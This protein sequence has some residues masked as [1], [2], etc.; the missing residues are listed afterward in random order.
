MT[1]KH[2]FSKEFDKLHTD[3]QNIIVKRT[4]KSFLLGFMVG[5]WVVIISCMIAS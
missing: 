5:V 3:I 2:F 4:V 1:E